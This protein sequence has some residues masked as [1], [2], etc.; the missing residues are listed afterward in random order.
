MRAILNAK[1]AAESA[2]SALQQALADGTLTA[3]DSLRLERTISSN[4][5][6]VTKTLAFRSAEDLR[7]ML[8]EGKLDFRRAQYMEQS[9][10]KGMAIIVDEARQVKGMYLSLI[11]I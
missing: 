1:L 7:I 9:I 5:R 6:N 4:E 2:T 8:D 3:E 10:E 11:H